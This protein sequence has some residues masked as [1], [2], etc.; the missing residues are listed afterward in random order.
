MGVGPS[1][2]ARD[3]HARSESPIDVRMISRWTIVRAP[4]VIAGVLLL[5]TTAGCPISPKF[6]KPQVPLN[7]SWSA[8][9][10][11]RLATQ[12]AIDVAWWKAFNDPSLDRLIE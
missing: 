6:L 10:D 12:T 2:E 1:E 7:A 8:Q 3:Q 5:V 4:V 9:G 11:R